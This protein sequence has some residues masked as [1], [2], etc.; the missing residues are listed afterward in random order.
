MLTLRS[1][2]CPVDFSD[3]SRHAL[4][5]AVALA[6]QHDS[7][8]IVLTAIEPLL[9]HAAQARF[10]LDLKTE[11]EA[12]LREFVAAVLPATASWAPGS[13]LEV[14][15]G[16]ASAVILEAADQHRADLIV[17]GTHGLGGFRRLL[18]GSTT[19]R[20]LR[21]TH[22]SV[23]AVPPAGD[24]SV[25]LDSAGPRFDIRTIL[26]AT[27]FG[28][29][30][31]RAV[32]M[33]AD[34][35]QEFAVPLVV[36]HIVTPIAVADAWQRYVKPVDQERLAQARNQLEDWSKS[37]PANVQREI[38]V[39]LGRPAESIASIAEE[40]GAGLIA[41]GLSGDHGILAP[42]PGSTA[43]RALSIARVPVLVVSARSGAPRV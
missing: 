8:L 31:A 33:A 2:L 3:P 7:A 25:V 23:L 1:I 10:N 12:A 29:P 9:T 17:M 38:V 19:E 16:D 34:L 20:V 24:A 40:R 28:E 43:Y 21:R 37:L 27:D 6:A 36:A 35:A 14:R 41:M 22:T 30:S 15:V 26:A 42:R 32:Q 11:T 4:G 5:W 18:V 13:S 39:L